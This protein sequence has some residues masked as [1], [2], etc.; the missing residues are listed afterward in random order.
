MTKSNEFLADHAI[1]NEF[2]RLLSKYKHEMIFM[3]TKISNTKETHKFIL[4]L[5]QR[6]DIRSSSKHVTLQNLPIKCTCKNIRQQYIN[7]KMRVIDPVKYIKI[8]RE[9]FKM[10]SLN[11][12]MVLIQCRILRIIPSIL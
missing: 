9:Q 7:I 6:L 4:Y 11:Y 10:M 1:N 3:N 8:K 2:S 12:L 5:S